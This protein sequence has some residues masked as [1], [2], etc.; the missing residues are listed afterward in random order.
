[1]QRHST[2][3]VLS[4]GFATS[5]GLTF[6]VVIVSLL[7]LNNSNRRIDHLVNANNTKSTLIHQ[8]RTAARE[9]TVNLQNMLILDDPFLQ[10]EEWMKINN[11][12]ATFANARMQL[13]QQAL[14]PEERRL[15]DEQGKLTATVGDLHLQ[16]AELILAG[17]KTR[18]NEMLQQ[19]AMP[20]QRKTFELLSRLLDIQA[21][22]AA[23]SLRDARQDYRHTLVSILALMI[24]IAVLGVAIARFAMRR[25]T[26]TEQHLYAA[27][28]H[29]QITLHSIG[30]GV[31]TTD[32]QGRI[33]Q[34][35]PEAERLTGW[36][37]QSAIG[38][39]IAKVFAAYREPGDNSLLDP[40]ILALQE[41]RSVTT[42]S[43]VML[44]N[45][46]GRSFAIEYTAAPI[47][48]QTH[49]TATGAV[50]VF[51]DVSQMRL[52]ASELAYQ[53]RHDMLTGLMNRREFEHHLATT[54]GH[55]P[56]H[57]DEPDWLC[58]LDLDQFKLINDTCGHL[59]GDELL[60]QVSR[61]MQS[62]LREADLLAR[63]GG[64]EFAL[65]L[66]RCTAESAT[67]I[68]E[69]I[70][71]TLVATGFVW[72][73]KTFNI[74]GSFGIVPITSDKLTLYDLMSS[75][76]AACYVAKDEGRNRIHIHQGDDDA[77]AHRTTEMHWAHRIKQALEDDRFILYHQPISAL[78]GRV[79]NVHTEILVRMLDENGALVTPTA[80]I[81]AAERY[82]LMV[83]ID[84]WVV[85][86]T[87]HT[88]RH[89]VLCAAPDTCTI[90]INLSA[91]SLCDDGFLPFV[92]QEF[93]SQEID[94]SHI[95]FEITE[96]CAIINLSRAIHFISTLRARGCRFALDDFG[97]G[98]SSFGYLK[99]LRVE[100]L[101]IDG[102][103]VRNIETDAMDLAM[104]E[105]I[106][107]IG[108]VAGI[109]TIAEYVENSAILDTLR[110]LGV[111]YA[112]GY[113]IA[114]PEPLHLITQAPSRQAARSQD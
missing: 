26:N 110:R 39:P 41:Q 17:D 72:E 106:N 102:S 29:A 107:Q 3:S 90:A 64:D 36:S 43:D 13:L 10:D 32:V 79:Y 77:A 63:M 54:L 96:T 21:E 105:S 27:T 47:F 9:R 91:Q 61:A 4:L 111:D 57:T 100:Y 53:A 75:A 114:I 112:Q 103:F 59:A 78:Q 88:F 8:M 83:E 67:H 56:T 40:V 30:D 98:L 69:R 84:R 101:K 94:P 93:S 34:I 46:N 95:C 81:P 66:S 109:Q 80:F 33:T 18:A 23:K 1:M 58:Y 87:L 55:A 97:S 35:N 65:L 15:L 85:R 44:K 104:V 73:G 51:R 5:L 92:L 28:E 74:S 7:M 42:D 60:K 108:H 11:N 25:I 70:R 52:I 38:Q 20:G 2:R 86:Q 31:I 68:V 48:N 45:G 76:D 22:A 50:L 71:H 24:G 113:G 82:N 62:Q 49:N 89:S 12:G 14:T 37:A 19:Q 16:I 99:N 6:A